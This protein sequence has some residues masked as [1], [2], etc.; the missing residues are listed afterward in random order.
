M[1]N[2]SYICGAEQTIFPT[3]T[4]LGGVPDYIPCGYGLFLQ[5]QM[6]ASLSLYIQTN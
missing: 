5:K 4:D 6:G 1:V 2:N 3:N